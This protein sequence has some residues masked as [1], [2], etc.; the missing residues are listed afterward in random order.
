[1]KIE[2][3]LVVN[4]IRIKSWFILFIIP[5]PINDFDLGLSFTL[6]IDLHIIVYLWAFLTY[7][8]LSVW[9]MMKSNVGHE[10]NDDLWCN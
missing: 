7:S 1:M 2:S 8:V 4:G 3:I 6:T 9:H 10:S 5:M